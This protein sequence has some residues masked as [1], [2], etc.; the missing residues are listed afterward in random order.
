MFAGLGLIA[1]AAMSAIMFGD[2][3]KFARG[4]I[5]RSSLYNET[6]VTLHACGRA[7]CGRY[8]MWRPGA[9]REWARELTGPTGFHLFR[10]YAPNRYCHHC[11]RTKLVEVQVGEAFV[12]LALL[13]PYNESLARGTSN[14]TPGSWVRRVSPLRKPEG[15]W[16]FADPTAYP[17]AEP[18]YGDRRAFERRLNATLNATLDDGGNHTAAHHHNRTAESDESGERRRARK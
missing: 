8:P 7:S 5:I 16:G 14:A 15:G 10:T 2:Q 11:G 1:A 4:Y 9:K 13:A 3:R 6:V 18:V 12:G 17:V